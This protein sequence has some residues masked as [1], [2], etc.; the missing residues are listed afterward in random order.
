MG[1]VDLLHSIP[2][3]RGLNSSNIGWASA[4]ISKFMGPTWGLPGAARSQVGPM[5]AP[6]TLL[7]G[8]ICHSNCKA[9]D[10]T[11]LSLQLT[12]SSDTRRWNLWMPDP[13]MTCPELDIVYQNGIIHQ[14]DMLYQTKNHSQ[15][16][17]CWFILK[18]INDILK[19]WIVSLIWLDPKD[20]INSGT[21]IHVCPTHPIP[22]PLMLWQLVL[23]W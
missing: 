13:Q 1:R 9:Y 22:C 16:L 12:W 10:L 5:L 2:V 23:G 8:R 4:Q 21:T 6:W 17:T 11:T 7:S 14:G 18:I 3:M 19:L 15:L 20:A